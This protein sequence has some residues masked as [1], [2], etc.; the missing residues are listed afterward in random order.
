[1]DLRVGGREVSSN[2]LW[3]IFIMWE[4]I[5]TVIKRPDS[6]SQKY[7]NPVIVMKVAFWQ[8]ESTEIQKK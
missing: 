2:L 1:M 8:L 7:L 3:V 5:I 4:Y 6:V